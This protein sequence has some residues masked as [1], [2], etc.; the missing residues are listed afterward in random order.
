MQEA[1]YTFSR[2]KGAH[3]NGGGSGWSPEGIAKYEELYK[4]VK[5]SRKTKQAE[6]FNQELLKMFQA[7]RKRESGPGGRAQMR[8]QEETNKRAYRCI[9][10]LNDSSSDDDDDDEGEDVQEVIYKS[11]VPSTDPFHTV[12]N[13]AE[14]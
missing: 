10:E 8:R 5:Y 14:V 13:K 4:A 9:N 3:D 1:L 2:N 7:R 11:A 6:T 12:K